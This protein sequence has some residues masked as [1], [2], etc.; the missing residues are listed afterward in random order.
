M[1]FIGA[2]PFLLSSA[3]PGVGNFPGSFLNARTLC[4][5][6]RTN[7]HSERPVH[8]KKQKFE[9]EVVIVFLVRPQLLVN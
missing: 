2:V 5:A 3:V 9:Y 1:C 7:E 8:V 4:F 6:A